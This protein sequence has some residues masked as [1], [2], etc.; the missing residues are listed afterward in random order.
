MHC[1]FVI[2]M[3]WIVFSLYV[4]TIIGLNVVGKERVRKYYPKYV[5]LV[6]SIIMTEQF[7]VNMDQKKITII[8]TLNDGMVIQDSLCANT[9]QSNNVLKSLKPFVNCFTL[10]QE[11]C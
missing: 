8:A 10:M 4:L 11:D 1:I 2:V 9:W 5:L 6:M 3:S 7:L